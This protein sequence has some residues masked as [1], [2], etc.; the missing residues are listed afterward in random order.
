MKLAI[1]IKDFS[2]PYMPQSCLMYVIQRNQFYFCTWKFKA[3]FGLV[4]FFNV[5]VLCE[6]QYLI[7]EVFSVFCFGK[8]MVAYSR[9]LRLFTMVIRAN[10]LGK[11]NE[12]SPMLFPECMYLCKFQIPPISCVLSQNFINKDREY[13][14]NKTNTSTQK[15]QYISS[16]ARI[17]I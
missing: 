6:Y 15:L 8:C 12:Q 1:W 2:F 11:G 13:L 5:F 4:L 9:A 17:N 3:G 10:N 7:R 16:Q 14:S